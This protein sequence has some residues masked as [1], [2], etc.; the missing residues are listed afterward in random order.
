MTV[1]LLEKDQAVNRKRV[2]RL[3]RLMGLEAIYPKPRLSQRDGDHRIYPYLLRGLKVERP[4]QV[5]AA[6]ITYIP[7]S[8]GF[9]YLVAIIDWY[10]RCVLSWRLSN[11]LESTFCVEALEDAL[12]Q[13]QPEIF[14]TDQGVQFTSRLF[15]DRLARLASRSAWM[16][17]GGRWTMCSWS[18]CGGV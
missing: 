9:M 11:S 13:Q 14:N 7:M 12:T 1:W 2:Q 4:N 5:W 6:D 3:M 8:Q 16:G 15:T 18:D 17:V 10:S